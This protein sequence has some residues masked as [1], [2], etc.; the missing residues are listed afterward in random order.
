[1]KDSEVHT[2]FAR[3]LATLTSVKVIK[4]HQGGDRPALP[5]IVVNFTTTSEVRAHA[6]F[7]DYDDDNALGDV[8]ATP[9]IETE[10]VM[11]VHAYGAPAVNPKTGAV[12]SPPPAAP[13]D[14]LRPVRAAAQL[15][16]KNEPMMP[17]L[18]VHDVSALRNVPDFVNERWEPRAQMD[19]FLRGIVKDGFII[20]TIE[21]Y[22]FDFER[23]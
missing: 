16:Q 21:T 19:V 2:A 13:S 4:A 10:W 11:S 3:W 12:V 6:Q 15:A 14:I 5:Y 1:V 22:S 23:D 8:V 20:D 17:G 18:T 9:Q 7:D